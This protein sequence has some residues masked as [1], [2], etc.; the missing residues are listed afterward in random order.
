MSNQQS[1]PD[2]AFDSIERLSEMSREEIDELPYGFMVLDREGN[3]M[4]YNRYESS[5]SRLDPLRVTGKNFF[6]RIAPCTRVQAFEGRFRKFVE[7]DGDAIERFA[8]RF[9]FEHGVQ[10]VLVQFARTP[11]RDRVFLTVVRR[12]V[13][14]RPT[15]ERIEPMHVDEDS[16]GAVGPQGELLGAPVDALLGLLARTAAETTRDFGLQWG[17]ALVRSIERHCYGELGAPLVDVGTADA[18]RML[19][20]AFVHAGLGRV[21]VDVSQRG[22]GPLELVVRAPSAHGGELLA[23]LYESILEPIANA[24]D[25]RGGLRVAC[26]DFAEV[27]VTPWR[28]VADRADAIA[29]IVRARH[30]TPAMPPHA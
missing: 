15:P 20:L 18:T 14:S 12:H 28:F 24:L 10:D 2:F 19:D 13:S 7:G 30:E 16:G 27:H 22:L 8:F 26:L 25:S 29:Q 4:L 9:R 6:T 17:A 23:R 3:V 1:S 11:D 5:M 21:N